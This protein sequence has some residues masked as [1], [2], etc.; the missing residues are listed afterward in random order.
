MESE[1]EKVRSGVPQGTVLGPLLFILYIN[2]IVEAIRNCAI[3][4]FAD[5]SKLIKNI[6]SEEDK[7][8]M[9]EDLKAVINWANMNKM[10]LNEE[11]FML[12]QH[13]KNNE[14][15][16][17]YRINENLLL[18][19]SEYAKDLGILVDKDLKWSYHIATI[20]TSA[21]QLAGWV[22]RVFKNRTKE[23]ILTLYK[24]LIRPKLEYGCVVWN[25]HLIS[26]IAKLEAVQRTITFKI[27]NMSNYNYWERLKHLDL[28]SMQRRRERYICIHM[29]KIFT[30]L[31]PNNINLSFYETYRHGPRCRRK[32]LTSKYHS[33]NTLRTSSFS[34]V[35]ASLFNI[36]PR[37][38]KAAKTLETFKA[39]LDILLRSLPDC[40]PIQGYVRQNTNSIKDWL[41]HEQTSSWRNTSQDSAE[42]DEQLIGEVVQRRLTQPAR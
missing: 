19:Q 33:V 29:Y 38:L 14:I 17:P 10:E 41:Q 32:K 28:Y 25:P 2:N 18:Q 1:S 15:K 40:P 8:K 39:K 16:T 37:K 4:I 11:K 7:H 20:T 30:G 22:M 26:D 9:L 23:V 31:L 21:T 3:K 5:D 42:E 34:D 12:L 24:S 6:E 35:G 13:G 27:E 36:L